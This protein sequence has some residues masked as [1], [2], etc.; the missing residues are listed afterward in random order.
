MEE[1]ILQFEKRFFIVI[2]ASPSHRY[3]TK[4]IHERGGQSERIP[5]G[6]LGAGRPRAP[7]PCGFAAH[8]NAAEISRVSNSLRV[9]ALITIT[10]WM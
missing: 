4:L 10:S 2:P 9:R 7:S 5:S 8:F 1:L 6:K 3:E